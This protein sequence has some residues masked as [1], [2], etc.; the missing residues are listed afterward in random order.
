MTGL[1]APRYART[2]AIL[3][4]VLTLVRLSV[5]SIVGVGDAEAYYWT[6]S[7]HLSLSYLDHPPM[8]A[9]MIALSTALGG[10]SQ[11]F[12][13]LGPVLVFAATSI[14]VY[15]LAADVSGRPRVGLAALVLFELTP[16]FAIGGQGANPDVPLGLFWLLTAW[17]LWTATTGEKRG[18]VWLA[19]L[20]LGL[21]FLSKY[22]AV[23]LVVSAGLWLA[24]REH[25]H[26]WRRS[27]LYG[28]MLIALACTIPV[29]AWNSQ[30][31]WASLRL[32]VTRHSAAGVTPSQ[33][34]MFLGG[35]ALYYSPLL[36]GAYLYALV[37]AARRGLR[38]RGDDSPERRRAY[39]FVALLAL[40]TLSVFT[41]VGLWTPESEPHWTAMGFLPLV[42]G[43]AMLW[44][45]RWPA[46]GAPTPRLR[47]FAWIACGL[48]G[49]LLVLLHVHILT[50]LLLPLIPERDR[51]VD[52][53]AE[54]SGWPEVG[55]RTRAIAAAMQNPVLLHYHYTKCSQLWLSV[56]GELPLACLND[57]EDQYDFWQDEAAL[58]GRNMVYVTDA[59]Y[60]RDPA[61]LWRFDQCTEETPKLEIRRGG[62]QLRT[63]TFWRCEG[64]RGPVPTASRTS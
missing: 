8:V 51:P 31:E 61:T 59:V 64:Y 44:D 9:W 49:I 1:G 60:G 42:L 37:V 35:Q 56:N 4:A 23:L 39:A 57:R 28:A 47:R 48:P 36:W 22:F 34:G 58:V 55:A 16:A 50:P 11:F 14:L 13:R 20:S 26:W 46:G 62:F 10:S 38:G 45:E 29:I 41:V 52:I 19:G 53:V 43:T 30:H 27:E 2:A 18:R 21:A 32:H 24:R 54:L 40:P 17:L 3:I 5:I 25:R 15:R 6:W 12:I 7:Q 33:V 63:F